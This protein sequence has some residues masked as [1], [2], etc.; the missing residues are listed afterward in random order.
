M[1][2]V[3]GS[4]FCWDRIGKVEDGNNVYRFVE[5]GIDDE[6]VLTKIPQNC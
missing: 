5:V 1:I 6:G 3:D 4:S 2:Y